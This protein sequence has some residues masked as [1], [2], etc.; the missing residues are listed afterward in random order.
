MS[1]SEQSNKRKKIHTTQAVEFVLA[2]FQTMSPCYISTEQPGIAQMAQGHNGDHF[3]IASCRVQTYSFLILVQ[4]FLLLK[5][6]THYT[7]RCRPTRKIARLQC[8]PQPIKRHQ[9]DTLIW[10]NPTKCLL[11][12]VGICRI[13]VN[14]PYAAR[15]C[16]IK[17]CW[18][19]D[20]DQCKWM[21][22]E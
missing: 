19:I 22:Y 10:Q 7:D 6:N 3:R 13:S 14:W 2:N 21:L 17:S 18:I 12:L 8:C 15:H 20:V 1:R 11:P 16:R 5:A 4:I 9:T